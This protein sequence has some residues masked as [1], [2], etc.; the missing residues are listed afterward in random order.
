MVLI[1]DAMFDVK[2]LREF[3][4]QTSA[5]EASNVGNKLSKL[6]EELQAEVV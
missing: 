6:T 5:N 4:Y 1:F 2:Q 3:N